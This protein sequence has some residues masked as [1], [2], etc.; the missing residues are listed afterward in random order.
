[1]I[2]DTSHPPCGWKNNTSP[3]KLGISCA[4]VCVSNLAVCERRG[5]VEGGQQ[6]SGQV[7]E[8]VQGKMAVYVGVEVEGRVGCCLL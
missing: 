1:M 6:W 5:G 4:C 7:G 2:F 8:V 3:Y